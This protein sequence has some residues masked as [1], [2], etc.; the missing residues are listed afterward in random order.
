M[1][2]RTRKNYSFLN[3]NFSNVE[4]LFLN[5]GKVSQMWKYFSTMKTFSIMKIF[6]NCEKVFQK[7]MSFTT[8]ER[9]F[10]C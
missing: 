1:V 5:G 7:L 6:L 4:G 3:V 2:I 8:I 10:N 9:F